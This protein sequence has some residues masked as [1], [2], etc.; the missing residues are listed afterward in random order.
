MRRMVA[1]V[2]VAMATHYSLVGVG[3]GEGVS[4]NR[5]MSGGRMRPNGRGKKAMWM[6]RWRKSVAVLICDRC[7]GDGGRV[8]N[9]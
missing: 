8:G 6:T 2:L 4:G 9:K 3:V 7:G 5:V 1:C